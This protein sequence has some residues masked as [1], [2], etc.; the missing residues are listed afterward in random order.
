MAIAPVADRG[1]TQNLTSETSTL[2]DLAAGASITV[3]NYLIARIA[4]DNSGTSGAATTAAISDP[5]GHTW[6]VGS[7]ANQDPG[8]A[9]A[10][11]SVRICYVK[12][13]SAYSNGDD[14]TFTW[15]NSTTAKSIVIEEWSGIHATTPVAVAE[16]GS[17]GASA[18]PSV[19][20]TPT[21][22]GQMAY[23]ALATEGPTGDTH[24]QADDPTDG[25]WLNLTRLSTTDGTAT[26]NATVFGGYK[27]VTGTGLQTFNPF[28]TSRDWAAMLIVFDAAA[29]GGPT[30][31]VVATVATVPAATV[32]TGSTVA[33]SA[34]QASATV[35]AVT[36]QG[37][38][39]TTPATVAA[40]ASVPAVSVSAG[41]N[42]TVSP[43]VVAATVTVGSVAVSTDSTVAPSTVS[44]SAAV[45]TPGLSTGSTAAPAT[46]QATSAVGAATLSTG[47]TITLTTVAGVAAIASP[48]VSGSVLTTPAT[49]AAVAGVGTVQV[50]TGA[51][52]P[53]TL[54]ATRTQ[55]SLAAANTTGLSASSGPA[56]SLTA[57]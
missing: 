56:S 33:P 32:S 52:V 19:T 21:A 23:G 30:P 18:F 49:I 42:A 46:V 40:T 1:S 34:V 39:G 53:G 7:A 13:T 44:G 20:R 55:P 5:R 45:G 16:L 50:T 51:I 48:T 43:A 37:G 25:T 14:I 57:T 8:N 26:N 4:I 22:A 17:N 36:A 35:P 12:V 10:G 28:I 29:A 24:D 38:A 27:L 9:N 15:G 41:G 54:H 3:G 11:I 2:V 6:T 47:S 31:S